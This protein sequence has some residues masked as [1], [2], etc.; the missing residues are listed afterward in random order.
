MSDDGP[1]ID[2]SIDELVLHGVPA[3]GRGQFEQAL[4]RELGR[5][6]AA[7]RRGSFTSGRIDLRRPID[8]RVGRGDSP[9][10]LGHQV[11]RAVHGALRRS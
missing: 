1:E 4:R 7:E 5:L 9:G 10:Q 3:S 8:L 6:L 2:L 11:A